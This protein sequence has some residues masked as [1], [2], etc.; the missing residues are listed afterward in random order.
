MDLHA[1]PGWDLYWRLCENYNVR[2][3]PLLSV[4]SVAMCIS[5][6]QVLPVYPVSHPAMFNIKIQCMHSF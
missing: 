3:M 1:D 6:M 4:R 2:H 5:S